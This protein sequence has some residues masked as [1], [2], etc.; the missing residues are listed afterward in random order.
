[1]ETS[2]LYKIA[3]NEGI[4]ID[5]FALPENTALSMKLGDK[6]YIAIDKNLLFGSASERVALAHELGHHTTGSLYLIDTASGERRKSER[7]ADR[8]AIEFL[9]PYA[10]LVSFA[11]QGNES[12][13]ALAEHFSVT[14][15]FMQKALKH[16]FENEVRA[17]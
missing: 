8:W 11:K 6:D 14:E 15:D 9:V 2:K 13:S 4:T 16:Y 12:L 10:E 5:F 3:E 17:G 1:M 7:L